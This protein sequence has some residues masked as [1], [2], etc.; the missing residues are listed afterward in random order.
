MASPPHEYE[1]IRT[2]LLQDMAGFQERLL[3]CGSP[4]MQPDERFIT[5]DITSLSNKQM[6]AYRMIW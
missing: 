1:L 5:L 2:R 4:H 3:K 6:A